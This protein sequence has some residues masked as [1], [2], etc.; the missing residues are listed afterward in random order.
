MPEAASDV[1]GHP[2][3]DKGDVDRAAKAG[4]DFEV[5]AISSHPVGAQ[6]FAE[7]YLRGSVLQPL[8]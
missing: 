3:A 8:F 1:D 2:R 4:Q 6:L 7:R 5:L